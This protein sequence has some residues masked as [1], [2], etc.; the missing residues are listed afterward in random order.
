MNL[1]GYAHG[2]PLYYL[3]KDGQIALP[4]PVIV[5]I[6]IGIAI[7][8]II[9]SRQ[10]QVSA[11][12]STPTNWQST[13]PGRCTQQRYDELKKAKETACGGGNR[14]FIWDSC[15]T[16]AGKIAGWGACANARWRLMSECFGGG[17]PRHWKP[18][19]WDEI[20]NGQAWCHSLW[21][22]KNCG[23]CPA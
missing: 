4:L 11:P 22:L 12:S 1:Y 10:N 13:P 21:S 19:I 8:I 16:I 7:A 14:C 9:Q 15:Q 23:G 17:D 6:G 20:A 2:N 3:D 5:G 18:E